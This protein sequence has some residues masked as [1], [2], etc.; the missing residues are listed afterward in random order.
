MNELKTKI[1]NINEEVTHDMENL[2]KRMK[3]KYKTQW[4]PLQQT[5]TSR[6]QNLRT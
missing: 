4:R 6:R 1:D 2:R 3:Q 5:R